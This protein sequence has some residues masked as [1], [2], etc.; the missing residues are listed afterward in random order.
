M[1]QNF[2]ICQK[3]QISSVTSAYVFLLHW[4]KILLHWLTN[5]QRVSTQNEK[6]SVC[7]CIYMDASWRTW[8]LNSK[9]TFS[10]DVTHIAFEYS[11]SCPRSFD[12]KTYGM[13]LLPVLIYAHVYKVKNWNRM[14][15]AAD[16][17]AYN[18]TSSAFFA[19]CEILVR[20]TS[21]IGTNGSRSVRNSY[22]FFTV[23]NVQFTNCEIC[24]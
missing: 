11:N 15:N 21:R 16:L 18:L 7:L 17:G 2:G 13:Y 6:T 9:E 3:T 10:R 24:G 5:L 12:R 4:L 22:Q 20:K 23:W 19:K 14:Q 1:R 8:S